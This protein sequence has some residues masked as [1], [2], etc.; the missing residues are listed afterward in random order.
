MAMKNIGI[1]AVLASR[2]LSIASWHSQDIFLSTIALLITDSIYCYLI[3]YRAKPKNLFP[4]QFT[5]NK[6]KIEIKRSNEVKDIDIKNQT[7]SFFNGIINIENFHPKNIKINGKSYK[8][9]IYYIGYV[10]V[11][12]SKDVN[13]YSVNHLRLIFRNAN[14]YFEEIN[15]IKNLT[16]VPTNESK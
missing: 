2:V 13:V 3:K 11:E 1:L 8:N 4:F 9:I 5:N 10:T 7:Y 14:G 15:K 12:D 6:L 16:L